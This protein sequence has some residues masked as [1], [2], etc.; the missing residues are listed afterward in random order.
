M[1]AVRGFSHTKLPPSI[2]PVPW[3]VRRIGMPTLA[4]VS[5]TGASSPRRTIGPRRVTMAPPFTA[6]QLSRV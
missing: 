3:I 6:M 4:S 5:V 1:T 2:S